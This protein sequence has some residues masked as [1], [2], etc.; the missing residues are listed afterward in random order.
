MIP[1]REFVRSIAVAA[2]FVAAKPAL[3]AVGGERRVSRSSA[4]GL[5]DCAEFER[6]CGTKFRVTGERSGGQW[7]ELDQVLKHSRGG[8]VESFSVRFRGW[9][10][11]Q[12]PERTYRF[13]HTECG[14]FDFFIT[15]GSIE[16]DQCSYRAVVCR[17]I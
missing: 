3:N 4:Q 8:R 9:S 1:R 11:T 7:L 15:P 6:L 5:P 2:A 12:L 10:R 13:A 14:A 17:L 16:G